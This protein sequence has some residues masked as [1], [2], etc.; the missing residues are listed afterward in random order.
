MFLISGY[1]H[2]RFV[3]TSSMEGFTAKMLDLRTALH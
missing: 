1:A 2:C 3:G